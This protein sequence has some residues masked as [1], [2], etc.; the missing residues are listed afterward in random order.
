M[1]PW[2]A[3]RTSTCPTRD[4]PGE[5]EDGQERRLQHR[6]DLGHHEHAAPVPPGRWS[7]P[8]VPERGE[9]WASGPQSRP[10]PSTSAECVR[11]YTSPA[12]GDARQPCADERRALAGE[13]EAV[14]AGAKGPADCR[15]GRVFSRSPSASSN[16]RQA[17]LCKSPTVRQSEV[18]RPSENRLSGYHGRVA[19]IAG[20]CILEP[21]G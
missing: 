1:R 4:P 20:K 21:N 12:H 9:T 19:L 10:P 11:R 8:A 3:P 13:E 14:P 16:M 18:C 15:Q 17:A 6:E 7:T 5:G 2:N